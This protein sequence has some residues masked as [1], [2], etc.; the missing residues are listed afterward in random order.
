MGC[1]GATNPKH[2]FS[3][4]SY[5]SV[6]KGDEHGSVIVA[7]DPANSKLIKVLRDDGPDRMPF[8]MDPLPAEDIAKIEAWI[9]A[10]AKNE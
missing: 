1:H 8:K 3:V 2:G 4:V 6:M 10:G 9:S 5:E 7:G